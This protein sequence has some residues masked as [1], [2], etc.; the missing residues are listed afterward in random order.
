MAGGM[1]AGHGR[2]L[3]ERVGPGAQQPA[4]SAA[5]APQPDSSQQAQPEAPPGTGCWIRPDHPTTPGVILGWQHHDDG[6]WYALVSAWLPRS[7]LEPR[8]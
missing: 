3:H 1:N 5:P 8:S 2:P 7:S 4:A 6:Q